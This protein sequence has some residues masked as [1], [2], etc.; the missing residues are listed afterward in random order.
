MNNSTAADGLSAS[1]GILDTDVAYVTHEDVA[2]CPLASGW[3]VAKLG[4]GR[5]REDDFDPDSVLYSK[6]ADPGEG[7]LSA[8]S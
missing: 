5:V 8:D 2:K 7:K 4:P 3:C 6:A 1:W